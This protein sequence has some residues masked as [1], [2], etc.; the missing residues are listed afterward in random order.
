MRNTLLLLLALLVVGCASDTHLHVLGAYRL[1]DGRVV[2]IRRSVGDTLRYRIYPTGETGRLFPVENGQWVSGDGFSNR[3]PVALQV[4]F[5][6]TGG[7]TWHPTEAAQ[8]TGSR[9]LDVE[10]VE[11]VSDGATLRGQLLLPRGEGP[12]PAVALIHGSG[13]DSAMEFFYSGDFMAA[14]GVA[15]LIY[16]KRGSGSSEGEFT[17][18]FDQLAR[19]GVAAVGVLA[20]NPAVDP[21]RIGLCGYSQGAW[22]A[23]L[24]AFKDPRISFVSVAYGMIESPTDEA[25]WETQNLL[26]TRGVDEAGVQEATSLIEASVG[27]VASGFADGWEEFEEAKRSTEGAAWLQKLEGSPVQKM[28]TYP[29]WLTKII[30]PRLAPKGLDWRYSSD[31]VLESLSIPMTW[32]LAAEDASAPNDLTIAKLRK[33]RAEGK[34]FELIVFPGADHTMLLFTESDGQR[35]Y[36]GYASGYFQAEVENVLRMSAP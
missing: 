6:E 35:V 32:L 14:N 1:E 13:D 3:E 31:E 21:N 36:T 9:F 26:R 19:D 34:P 5:E 20:S 2:S 28:L 7:L 22:V 8:Q 10:N 17:F 23:P 30:G 27:V 12:F 24:A 25:I 29:R 33:Y 18:D 16:D 11:F 4:A 15:A